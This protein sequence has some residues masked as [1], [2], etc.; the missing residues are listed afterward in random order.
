MKLTVFVHPNSKKPRVDKDLLGDLHVYVHE[1]PLEGR[2][3]LAVIE[4]LAQY[5]KVSKSQVMLVSGG[6]SKRKIFNVQV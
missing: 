1:P 6:K 5:F 2:A 4:A 3:N